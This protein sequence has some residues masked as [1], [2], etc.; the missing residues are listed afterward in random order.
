MHICVYAPSPYIYSAPHFLKS[1]TFPNATE[2]LSKAARFSFT[3]SSM[4]SS[5]C[6]YFTPT[7]D[8]T[9]TKRG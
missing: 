8:P 5:T 3:R 2:G 4:A 6:T 7:Q 1:K 9:K